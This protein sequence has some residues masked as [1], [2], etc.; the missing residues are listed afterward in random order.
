MP[1][2]YV[3]G[4]DIG[5]TNTSAGVM[6]PTGETLSRETIPTEAET[7]NQASLTPLCQLIDRVIEKAQ[8]QR[9]QI[10]GIGVGCTGP[11]NAVTGRV[12]NPF[13]LPT[14][15]DV[16]LVDILKQDFGLP[17]LLLNDAHA[18]ALGEYW[19]GAGRGTQTMIYMT[20]STGIG[21]GMIL[22]GQL[23]RGAGL[24]SSEVGHQAID[25]EGP[26]CYCGGRG[27]LEMLA[28][29]PAIAQRAIETAPQNSLVVEMAARQG[30]S[31]TA[32]T[33]G[34]AADAGDEFAKELLQEVGGYLGVGIANLLNIITPNKVVIGGG[35]MRSWDHIMPSALNV[36]RAR[37]KM[38]PDLDIVIARTELQNAGVVGAARHV[39]DFMGQN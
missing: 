13:T 9:G 37:G 15:E 16:P 34:E 1:I 21:G 3:V 23:Y 19:L 14:W 35:V 32:R 18:A 25:L 2:E 17:V 29:G 38:L 27:C 30:E 36:I 22:N 6:T 8:L 4:V 33:V 10:G 7:W 39:F 12:Q 20:V 11:V 24:L 31:I 5:G 26:E 28:A